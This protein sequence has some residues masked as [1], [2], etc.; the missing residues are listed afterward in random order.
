MGR[1]VRRLGGLGDKLRL[2]ADDV[3]GEETSMNRLYKHMD[4]SEVAF[5][6]LVC[7]IAMWVQWIV[8][9]ILKMNKF[10]RQLYCQHLWHPKEIERNRTL[11]PGDRPPKIWPFPTVAG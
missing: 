3:S 1:L 5:T 9:E 6:C 2:C 8:Y 4:G 10:C 7:G 11:Q